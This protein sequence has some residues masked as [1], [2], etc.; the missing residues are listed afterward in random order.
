MWGIARAL[1]GR[2]QL[3]VEDHDQSRTRREFE[4]SI[5]DDLEW[6]GFVPDSPSIA[7]YARPADARAAR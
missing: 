7:T 5:L 3:R 2:V 1:G 4:T 6:L